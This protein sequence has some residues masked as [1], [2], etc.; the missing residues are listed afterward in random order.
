MVRK[1]T[2]MTDYINLHTGNAIRFGERAEINQHWLQFVLQRINNVGIDQT[3]PG[4]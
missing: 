2:G 3:V 4:C 1:G